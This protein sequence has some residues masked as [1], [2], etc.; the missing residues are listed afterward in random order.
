MDI[1]LNDI[2][3]ITKFYIDSL[4][5]SK[6]CTNS[7]N[8]IIVFIDNTV[9]EN[10]INEVINL[11]ENSQLITENDDNK[12]I[13]LFS[14]GIFSNLCRSKKGF[15]WLFNKIGLAKFINIAKLTDNLDILSAV[16]QLLVNY[17]QNESPKE[18]LTPLLD[19]IFT[20]IKKCLNFEGRTENLITCSY[21][22]SG[23]IYK[24]DFMERMIPISILIII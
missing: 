14:N 17:F 21:L 24:L 8:A 16:M 18:D 1:L 22:L 5:L 6:N 20:V 15:E 7:E 19:D 9:A 13:F 23:L 10:I 3:K 2:G 11:Y 4:E 12:S